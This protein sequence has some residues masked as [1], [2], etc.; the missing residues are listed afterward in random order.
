MIRA[1]LSTE[2]RRWWA[3]AV[4]LLLIAVACLTA[5]L[6]A[7]N[8]ALAGPFPPRATT[9]SS[10]GASQTAPS[11]TATATA[12]AAARPEVP[13]L[14]VQRSA[15]VSLRIPAIELT[16]SLSQLGLNSDGTV[17]VPTDFQEPGWF[18]LGPSPGQVGSAV[19][20]GHVDSYEG[21]AVFFRLQSLQVGDVVE[22]G[23]ADGSLARFEVNRVATYPKEQFPA[24]EVYAS[25][26][27]S[28]L[29]LVTCGGEFDTETRHYRSNVVAYTTLVT[30]SS[31]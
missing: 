21:P 13:E 16:E 22:V 31:G 10:A 14:P 2:R 28:A 15:P 29:Q 26:G 25:H 3:A 9:P 11:S 19:I 17:E 27:Y 8:D 1:A 12:T 6:R 5:G 18:R 7:D 23:L 24:E 30:Y 4:V 20:L